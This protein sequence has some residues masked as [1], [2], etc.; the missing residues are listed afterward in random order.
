MI[1]YFKEE[2]RDKKVKTNMREENNPKGIGY[3][4]PK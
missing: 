4:I 3:W 1:Q 2:N